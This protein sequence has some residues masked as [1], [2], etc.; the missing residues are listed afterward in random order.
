M[1]T[2]PTTLLYCLEGLQTLDIEWE[3]LLKFQG[4]DGSVGCSPAAAVAVYMNTGDKKCLSYL[5]AMVKTFNNAGKREIRV[6]T[7]PS[8]LP[9]STVLVT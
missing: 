3:K 5:E 7:L 8:L 9:S 2:Q 6:L 4:A 1:Y